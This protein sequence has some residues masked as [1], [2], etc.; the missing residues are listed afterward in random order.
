MVALLMI[1]SIF[2]SGCMMKR[3]L[4]GAGS[5]DEI[6]AADFAVLRINEFVA[7][8]SE[9]K[10]EYGTTED[11]LEIYNPGTRDIKLEEGRW[12]ITDEALVDPE[13]FALPEVTI[14]AG[15]FLLLWCDGLSIVDE[16][17]HTNFRLSSGGEELGLF[18]DE[19]KKLR[20][21]DSYS[22]GA[23]KQKA[24]SYGRMLDGDAD[25]GVFAHPTPGSPNQQF[26]TK[27]KK[28]QAGI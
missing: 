6:E 2:G 18:Y 23:Q 27:G 4:V 9:N 13:R 28:N 21:I 20:L 17:I 14:P 16:E 7:K 25:W 10:N 12:Y 15:G 5:L 22:F 1:V 26:E 24:V 19:G 3:N 8:G 11:W